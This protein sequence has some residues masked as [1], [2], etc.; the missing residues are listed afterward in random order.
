MRQPLRLGIDIRDLRTAVSGQ[1]TYLQEL[2]LA[3][4]AHEG[5]GLEVVLFSPAGQV[6]SSNRKWFRLLEHFRLHFWKQVTLPLKAWAKGCDVLFT[7]DYF[8]PYFR[9]G[10][11]T[12][13]VFHDAFFFENKEHYSPFFLKFFHRIAVPSALRCSKI[14]V[15]SLHV[16]NKLAC[17]L[18]VPEEKLVPI[19]EAPKSFERKQ[20]P[21]AVQQ[22]RLKQFGLIGEP[23]L[24]HVGMLNKRKNIPMLIQAFKEVLVLM[25]HLK[26]VLAGSMDTTSHINDKAAIEKA[27]R[28]TGLGSKVV[29]TG[30]LPDEDLSI[31]YSHALL[32]V[33]PSI[34][35][36]FGLPLLEAFAHGVPV[37]VANNS[38]LP[39]IGGDAVI[40]FDPWNS[41]DLAEK[42]V[43]VLSN[44][45][46]YNRMKKAGFDRLAHFSWQ[47]AALEL[48]A[49][50][51]G[52]V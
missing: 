11:K 51:R 22:D 16:K 47:K 9:P 24:L 50:C 26:L 48:V 21:L 8:V 5:K 29:L 40:S 41:K 13:T 3:L 19:Y 28:E 35:E 25:P 20:L 2:L 30:Y 43:A 39:E 14:I 10:F 42:I 34:N 18:N 23:Y 6:H 12:V 15:P 32:Y 49:V 7:S 45:E 38:C 17:F 4:K 52:I 27:I 1:K 33:F 31:L 46:E 37:L 36:G 44:N